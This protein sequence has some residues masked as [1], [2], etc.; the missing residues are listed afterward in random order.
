MSLSSY[1][2]L[3]CHSVTL[4]IT[5]P[6]FFFCRW[7]FFFYFIIMN[8]PAFFF[9]FLAPSKTEDRTFSVLYIYCCCTSTAAVPDTAPYSSIPLSLLL[10]TDT[11]TALLCTDH[12]DTLYTGRRLERE[13]N[14]EHTPPHQNTNL[15]H[16]HQ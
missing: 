5:W 10:Y 15:E 16:Y 4:S 13:R 8:S 2:S 6:V 12:T 7:R 3:C 9:F 14:R 1:P 11:I